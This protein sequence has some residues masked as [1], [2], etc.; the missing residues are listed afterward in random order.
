[1]PLG[2]LINGE[3]KELN[4]EAEGKP[5]GPQPRKRSGTGC[6]RPESMVGDLKPVDLCLTR[7]KPGENW[8]EDQTVA[9]V[10][11]ARTSLV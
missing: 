8:V 2:V 6:A 10:Q 4:S 11:I 1:M 3:V 7:L 5:K 9:D